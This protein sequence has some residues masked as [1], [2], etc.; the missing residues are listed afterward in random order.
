MPVADCLPCQASPA[1]V[2]L[3]LYVWTRELS[4]IN[5]VWH[6]LKIG[7]YLF[8]VDMW[9]RVL[10]WFTWHICAL[11]LLGKA[12]FSPRS[13]TYGAAAYLSCESGENFVT[14]TLKRNWREG[15]TP[16][17]GPS[18]LWIEDWVCGRTCLFWGLVLLCTPIWK[19]FSV[20]SFIA[21]L[22]HAGG[23]KKQFI[24]LC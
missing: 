5:G 20:H 21:L 23:M 18:A 3:F 4:K 9:K 14:Q 24:A 2:T 8:C 6:Q 10:F 13:H 19:P 11:W 12:W 7:H 16:L 22:C 1:Y 17:W 15:G